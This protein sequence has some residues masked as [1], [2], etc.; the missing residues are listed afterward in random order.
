MNEAKSRLKAWWDHELI[1]RPCISYWDFQN[2]EKSIKFEKVVEVLDPWYL[3]QNWDNF[4]TCLNDFENALKNLYFGGENIPRFFPNYGPGIMAAIFGIEPR[5]LSGTVWFEKKTSLKEIVPLLEDTQINMNNPWHAR[6]TKITKIAA[7]RGKKDYSV[8]LT[9]LGGVL[10]ILS[11][12][13]G[14]EKLI[15]AMKDNPNVVDTCRAIILEKLLKVYDDLQTIIELHGD[16]CNSWLNLWC[17]KRWYP[18]QCDVSA[19]LSPKWFK[20]F[21]LPDLIT[22]AEHMDHALYHL[23]GPNQLNFLDEIL[24]IPSIHAIQ[25]VPGMGEEPKS[26]Y[27]WMPIYKKIQAAGKNIVIDLFEKPELLSH[28]YSQLDPKGL[29]TNVAF[30]DIYKSIFYLPEFIGG[31]GGSGD[32]KSFRR[33]F[34]KKMKTK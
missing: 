25:W 6:L 5:F 3:A 31:K 17:P 23:D 29:F 20:R 9:D 19:M 26:S 22:Q 21:V 18:I 27:K 1:D 14:P 13:L 33:E 24:S 16:G 30:F 2:G 28:F 8:A 12:F 15:F 4:D 10:D 11:S 34:R 32:F 7:E